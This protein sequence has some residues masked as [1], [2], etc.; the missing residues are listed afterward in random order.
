M[1]IGWTL[2]ALTFILVV[3]GCAMYL[4][5]GIGWA[6]LLWVLASGTAGGGVVMLLEEWRNGKEDDG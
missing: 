6:Q 4:E 2:I 1:T 3:L 5:G